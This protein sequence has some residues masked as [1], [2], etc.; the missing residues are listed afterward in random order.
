MELITS[1]GLRIGCNEWIYGYAWKSFDGECYI[2]TYIEKC[3]DYEVYPNSLGYATQ[4]LDVN[5]D[6]IF[7]GDIVEDLNGEIGYVYYDTIYASFSV[8]I[9]EDD[10]EDGTQVLSNDYISQN[11]PFYKIIGNLSEHPELFYKES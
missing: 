7:C 1:R 8:M 4:V 11:S 6:M 5:N 2:R 10:T 9:D 3:I